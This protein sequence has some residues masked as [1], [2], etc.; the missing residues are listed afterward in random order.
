[1]GGSFGDQAVAQRLHQIG[2]HTHFAEEELVRRF[3]KF[4]D[5][6]RRYLNIALRLGGLGNLWFLPTKATPTVYVYVPA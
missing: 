2:L 4:R 6:G 3:A 1:M 5:G